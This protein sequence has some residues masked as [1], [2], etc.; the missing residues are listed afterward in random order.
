MYLTRSLNKKD[1]ANCMN[2][3]TEFVFSR[4]VKFFSV[5][6]GLPRSIYILFGIKI[7]N[8]MGN[9]VFPFLAIFLTNKLGINKRDSGT[10]L[11]IAAL[12][13]APGS[14]LGGKL[15]DHF[16]R[17]KVFAFFQTASVILFIPCAFLNKSM[18]VPW[19]LIISSFMN[20]G[21]QPPLSAM[22]NDLTEPSNRN[23][24][25]SMLYLGNNIGFA[26]GS[27]IAGFLFTHFT[28]VLFLGNFLTGFAAVIILLRTIKETKPNNSDATTNKN[29]FREEA[30]EGDNLLKALYKRPYFLIFAI[31][32]AIY[33]FNYAQ[34]PFCGSIQ[35]GPSLYGVLMSLNGFVVIS[36]TTF[37]IKTTKNNKPLLNIA[38]AG[39]FFSIGFGMLYFIK[40]VPMFMLSTFIWTIGEI[41]NTTNSAVYIA[42][43][44]PSTHRGRFN[45]AVQIISG[46]GF[47]VGP[48]LMGMYLGGRGIRFAW[49]LV[50]FLEIGVALMILSLYYFEKKRTED[51]KHIKI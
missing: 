36:M 51:N 7:V 45:A 5:Y 10:L 41:L 46:S 1:D 37:I 12:A 8:A 19:L 44:T 6:K 24:A 14:I 34:F 20:G 21:S 43:N 35:A 11:T 49:P 33:S 39:V 47:A 48:Y 38:L 23:T 3:L 25:F 9:F 42:N 16:G 31:L 40:G 32:S 29:S 2:E 15:A 27:M 30:A 17:R 50:F 26:F 22:A 28:K 18:L 4:F 13:F